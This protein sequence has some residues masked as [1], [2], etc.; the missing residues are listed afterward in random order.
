MTLHNAKHTCFT[1]RE[2]KAH[3]EWHPFGPM[4]RWICHQCWRDKYA[5]PTPDPRHEEDC[6]REPGL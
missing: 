3:G 6:V 2:P 1:C 5:V 4:T